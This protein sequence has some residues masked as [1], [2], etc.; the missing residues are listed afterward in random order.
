MFPKRVS[1]PQP[2]ITN[3]LFIWKKNKQFKSK[4]C[5]LNASWKEQYL[6]SIIKTSLINVRMT[7][8]FFHFLAIKD[9]FIRVIRWAWNHHVPV[10]LRHQVCQ[11]KPRANRVREWTYFLLSLFLFLG[12]PWKVWKA[13]LSWRKLSEYQMSCWALV[14]RWSSSLGSDYS[15]V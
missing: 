9:G 4:I 10:G 15:W 11:W 13:L 6:V 8:P 12:G 5:F 2:F 14:G 1:N 7:N 3:I